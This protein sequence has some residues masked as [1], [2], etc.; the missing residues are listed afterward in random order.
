MWMRSTIV[1]QMMSYPYL[2]R[3]V[4]R[5]KKKTWKKEKEVQD[6][7]EQNFISHSGLQVEEHYPRQ[8][9]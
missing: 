8:N 9:L 1:W 4:R 6:K 5:K 3:L 7:M 2:V